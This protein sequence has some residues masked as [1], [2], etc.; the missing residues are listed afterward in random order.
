M[1]VA[2]ICVAEKVADQDKVGSAL[3]VGQ[4]TTAATEVL[5]SVGKK[6]A[7]MKTWALVSRT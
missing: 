5:R 3:L 7:A 2:L 6:L 4:A 1:C